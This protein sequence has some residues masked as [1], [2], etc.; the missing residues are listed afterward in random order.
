MKNVL[1]SNNNKPVIK[2][3]AS[4]SLKA[5]KNHIAILAIILAALLFTSV[6]TVALNLQS[7]IQDFTMRGQGGYPHAVLEHVTIDEYEELAADERWAETGYSIWVGYAV[8]ANLDKLPTEVRWSDDNNAKWT[9]A[10]PET[11]RMPEEEKEFATSD[12][13][14]KALGVPAELGT[15]VEL[16]IQLDKKTV[17]DTFTLCGIWDGSTVAYR[18]ML[19]L[20]RDYAEEIA[21]VA[22]GSSLGTNYST[23]DGFVFGSFMLPS[24]LNLEKQVAEIAMDYP[25]EAEFKANSAYSLS[26]VDPSGI[27]MVA[28][29]VL[30][31]LLA[32]ALL[33]YNI[34]Y[35]S[36]AQD[37]RFYGMLKTLGTTPTQIR[38]MVYKKALRLSAIGIP[39]GFLLGW[40]IGQ[41]LTPLIVGMMDSSVRV[42]RTANPVIFAGAAIFSLLTVFISCRKPAKL[43]AKVS[44]IEALRYVEQNSITRK[45][46]R[47]HRARMVH[48]AGQN[49]RRSRKK[50]SVV[51]LSLALSI[52]LL[53]TCFS[54][55]HSFDF[56]K[57]VEARTLTDFTVADAQSI[58]LSTPYS[59]VAVSQDFIAQAETLEG[60][61]NIGSI[62]ESFVNI[63]ITNEEVEKLQALGSDPEIAE[64]I[65]YQS[66]MVQLDYDIQI[67]PV[68][69][70]GM[71]EWP[72]SF[73]EVIEGELDMEKW[74]AGEG[75]FVTQMDIMSHSEPW[76][77]PG[78]TITIDSGSEMVIVSSHM[79]DI[80]QGNGTRKTYEVLAVVDFPVALDS[81]GSV[82]MCF[83]CFLPSEEFLSFYEAREDGYCA[84][85]TIFNVDDEHMAA[86]ENWVKNYTT[87][88]DGMLDYNSIAKLEESFSGVLAMF[89]IV[90][91]VLCAILAFIG[92]LNFI[93]SMTTSILTRHTE[94]AIL[95]AVGMTGRQVK[96][97]LIL[98][99]LGY[100]VLGFGLSLIL[101]ALANITIVQTLGNEL[102]FFTYD[103]TLTPALLCIIPLV[104]VTAIV[105]LICYRNM[106]K[107]SVVERLRKSE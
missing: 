32:G 62:Y 22:R 78:D 19:W 101:S 60:L 39:I 34:F 28:V 94:I 84:S 9:Y 80:P 1:L 35:I 37:T 67:W 107:Q 12:L 2:K 53:N 105:P 66:V 13:V 81:P 58:G 36:I 92:I 61:E 33:I 38:K 57:F 25:L 30:I 21:P 23:L 68:F 52:M 4:R 42:M 40:P 51:T 5:S 97:M 75:V 65:G 73:L 20:S 11:G 26:K 102:A 55:I 104:L 7:S 71:D 103:F 93:N 87:N 49:L 82:G 77:H 96:S 99:G 90:G 14:L 89:R 16:T 88:I 6:F 17:T 100:A 59:P 47:S 85:K 70:Y 10:Y 8:G 106:A 76:Y 64:N 29:A 48:M 69:L 24:A 56:E 72:A 3:L 98:E 44:P 45:S 27:L 46:R 31:V 18:Q 95:Q 91:G 41:L 86:A 74:L 54:V 63:P 50:V 15:Q 79:T 43:A 83:S